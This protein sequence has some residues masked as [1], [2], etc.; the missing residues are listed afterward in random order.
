MKISHDYLPCDGC[1]LPASPLHI[2][3]RVRRL[4]LSTRFRPVHIGVLFVALAPSVRPD[5]DFYDLA[6]S[7]EFTDPLLEALDIHSC[8]DGSAREFDAGAAKAARLAEFQRR[9]YFLACVSECP[10]PENAERAAS[11]LGRLGPTL[12]RRIRFNYRPKHIAPIGKELS[13]LVET[14]KLAGL[15]HILLLDNEQVL[16]VPRPGDKE[17]VEL[18]RRAVTSVVPRENL[19]S[20]YD[21][22]QLTRSERD[23]GARGNS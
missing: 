20:G 14:L 2:A 6:K 1:G 5:D 8:K 17:R 18:F 22:I 12:L 13:P 4:E 9:G 7:T 16:P 21:R 10:L 11:T 15:G 3:E 23:L 19:S